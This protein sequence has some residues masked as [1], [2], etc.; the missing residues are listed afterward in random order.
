MKH[1][2]YIDVIDRAREAGM[3]PLRFY[4]YRVLTAEFEERSEGMSEAR[5]QNLEDELEE[6]YVE[7][8][9]YY[10][11]LQRLMRARDEI[12][13]FNDADNGVSLTEAL[14]DRFDIPRKQVAEFVSRLNK[15]TKIPRLG[16]A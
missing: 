8:T 2:F 12:E 13:N 7:F 10:A 5:L 14:S 16:K 6:D 15:N 3:N 11:N 4:K 1:S 9:K